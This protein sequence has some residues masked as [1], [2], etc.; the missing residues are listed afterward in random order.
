ML[1]SGNVTQHTKCSKTLD[2]WVKLQKLKK[3]HRKQT[4]T[5]VRVKECITPAETMGGW[6]GSSSML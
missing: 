4:R 3:K 1:T 6:L 5:H 2:L